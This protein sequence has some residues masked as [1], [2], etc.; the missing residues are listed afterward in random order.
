[1][2]CEQCGN[3]VSEGANFC[4]KCGAKLHLSIKNGGDIKQPNAHKHPSGNAEPPENPSS[5]VV[6][7]SGVAPDSSSG[8]FGGIYHPWRRF[9]A[10]TVDLILFGLPVFGV[11]AFLFG[12][13]FPENVDIVIRQLENPIVAGVM[14]Y[15]VWIPIESMFL[16]VAGTTPAKWVFG[17]S[18]RTTSGSKL[19]YGDALKRTL[20][21]WVQGE[22]FGI[23]I[24]TLFT[25]LFAYRRLTKTGSTLWDEDVGSLVKHSEWGVVRAFFSVLV[26]VLALVVLSVLNAPTNS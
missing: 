21:L 14:V 1:M 4:G 17:I 20:L 13:F 3:E 10:R 6:E 15:V 9:F 22:G 2:Y 16:S 24:I 8:F 18:V 11:A 25:R 19:N 7:A 5:R 23:P 12:Y 26:V